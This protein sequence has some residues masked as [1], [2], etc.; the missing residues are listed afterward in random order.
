MMDLRQAGGWRDLARRDVTILNRAPGVSISKTS[1]AAGIAYWINE[2]YRLENDDRYTK[3]S[4]LVKELK[5]WVD[6]MYADGRTTVLSSGEIEKKIL[7]ITDINE[8]RG[9]SSIN[10]ANERTDLW[11]IH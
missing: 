3:D 2:H 7:E 10:K 8:R 6:E 11:G 1:G 5:E 4:S 9:S